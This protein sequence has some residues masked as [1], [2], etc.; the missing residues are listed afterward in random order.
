MTADRLLTSTEV[1]ELL[2]VKSSWV[3]EHARQG[4][5]RSVQLGRYRRFRRIDVDDFIERCLTGDITTRR[6]IRAA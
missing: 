3:D 5:L 4:D 6:K 1:A 2:G